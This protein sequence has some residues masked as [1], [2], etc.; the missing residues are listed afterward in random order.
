MARTDWTA[1]VTDPAQEYLARSELERLGMHPYLPQVRR[2]WTAPHG[3][4]KHLRN[5]P[6][7]PRY[8]FIPLNDVDPSMFALCRGVRKYKPVVSDQ[9]G[10]PWRVYNSHIQ[11]IR[12]AEQLRHFDDTFQKGDKVQINNG[13]FEGIEAFLENSSNNMVELFAPLLGG[14]RVKLPTHDISHAPAN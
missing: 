4:T 3:R 6:L 5:F 12:T 10:R 2:R 14:A 9:S 13:L 7:F 11:L 1:L 8:I